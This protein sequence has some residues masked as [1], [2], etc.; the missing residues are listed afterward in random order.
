MNATHFHVM[1]GNPGCLPDTNEVYEDFG[2]AYSAASELAMEFYGSATESWC[3]AEEQGEYAYF[4]ARRVG[5][6]FATATIEVVGCDD[7]QCEEGMG[8]AW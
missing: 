3:E 8:G 7:V 2:S 6:T 5:T 1:A 4:K